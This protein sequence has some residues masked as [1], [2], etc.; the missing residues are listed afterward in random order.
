MLNYIGKRLLQVI[1]VLLVVTLLIVCM[2]RFVPGDPVRSLLGDEGNPEQYAELRESFGL[3]KPI[4][5]QF[6]DY[7][8][9]AVKGDLGTSFFRHRPIH[10]EINSRLPSTFKIAIIATVTSAAIGIFF[11]VAAALHRGKFLDSLIMVFSLV[12]LSTPI[13]FLAII[14]MVIFGIKLPWLPVMSMGLTSWKAYVLP[15]V[16]LATQSVATV[17]RTMRSSM[18]DVLGEDYIRTAKAAGIPRHIVIYNNGLRNA[19]I[20]VITVVGVQFGQLLTG[21]VI[22][23]QVF[24]IN[25][26]GRYLVDNVMQRD[27]PAIQGSVLLFALIFVIVN[28]LTDLCYGLADPRVSF[29]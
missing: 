24:S 19:L 25:G 1:P 14:L 29:E 23:E 17:A 13:F 6:F 11:G 8:K 15:V 4:L 3:D 9:G 28:L 16:S 10:E 5:V 12:A 20:P 26:L 18:L 7:I 22:T 21:A 2:T 27:Y